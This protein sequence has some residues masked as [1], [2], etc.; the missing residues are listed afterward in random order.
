MNPHISQRQISELNVSS[1]TVC[2]IVRANHIHPYHINQELS[3]NDKI[4]RVTFCKCLVT[5]LHLRT[6]V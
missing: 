3:D 2:R 5:S 4:L 6:M 1:A